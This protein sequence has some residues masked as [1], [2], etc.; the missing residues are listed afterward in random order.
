MTSFEIALS[1]GSVAAA[2]LSIGYMAHLLR[3]SVQPMRVSKDR[4]D[5]FV[6]NA[7]YHRL[8]KRLTGRGLPK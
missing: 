8:D 1:V 7:P 5:R 6:Q 4:L 2:A 3:T